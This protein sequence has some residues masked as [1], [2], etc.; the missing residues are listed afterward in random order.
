[1]TTVPT[2]F[3]NIDG[4]ADMEPIP[5]P[6]GEQGPPGDEGPQ[7]PPGTQGQKGNT[8]DMGPQ[9]P[10]GLQGDKGDQGVEGT[11]GITPAF[12]VG[13]YIS[14]PLA[15]GVVLVTYTFVDTVVF[16]NNFAGSAGGA[17][18][19]PAA[20]YTIE[21]NKNGV[22]VGAVEIQTD[23]TIIFA[24]SPQT[25]VPNDTLSLTT[26]TVE[27]VVSDISVTLKGTR[28]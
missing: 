10:Q 1:M 8:G 3:H 12:S 27:D 4:V 14:G 15:A 20:N 6:P 22:L 11:P 13:A 18:T 7:G 26:T 25:F 24:G 28:T 23:G 9:G 17:V 21:I 5:G 19:P 16:D 2:S